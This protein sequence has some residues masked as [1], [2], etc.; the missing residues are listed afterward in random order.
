MIAWL[1]PGALAGLAAMAGPVIVHL[2]QRRRAARLPFPSLRFVHP[3]RSVAS[4][5]FRIDDPWLLAL[6]MAI[7]GLAASALAQPVLMLPGRVD[8]WNARTARAIVV[9]TSDSMRLFAAEAAAA[10]AA[11]GEARSAAYSFRI[12]GRDPGEGIRRAVAWLQSAPPARREIVLVSDMQ[13]G[14]LGRDI[15]GQVP[16][17]IGIRAVTVGAAPERHRFAGRTLAGTG[18][19]QSIEAT[20]R[21]TSVRVEPGG[22]QAEGLRLETVPGEE[23]GAVRLLRTIAAARTPAPSADQPI[24]VVFGDRTIDGPLSPVRTAWMRAAIVRIASDRDVRSGADASSAAGSSPPGAWM[25]VVRSPA[26]LPLVRGASIGPSLVLHV[27][28]GPD[29]FL[30]AAVVRAALIGRESVFAEHEIAR[31]PEPDLTAWSRDPAP[32]GPEAVIHVDRTDARWCWALVLALLG[33]ETVLRRS[34]MAVAREA[35]ADAA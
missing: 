1:N 4:R 10:E 35:H 20:P 16:A 8:G 24:V 28:E 30:G 21:Q 33:L 19:Q 14:S 31:I 22:G 32:V 2:L 29:G 9:D 23:A 13:A 26:G 18:D 15:A 7:V 11:D 17:G 25:T 6:R 3:G 12:E 34:R 27:A 5:V